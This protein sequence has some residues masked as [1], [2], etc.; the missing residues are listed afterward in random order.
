MRLGEISERA[1]LRGIYVYSEVHNKILYPLAIVL[2]GKTDL[3]VRHLREQ[4]E[5]ERAS[6]REQ[7]AYLDSLR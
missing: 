3:Q 5:A 6:V 7:G 2:Q 4:A 1:Y